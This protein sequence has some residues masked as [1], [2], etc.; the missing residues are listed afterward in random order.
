M[1]RKKSL[2]LFAAYA[3][4]IALL[5]IRTVY[6][7][8]ALFDR[9]VGESDRNRLRMRVEP[10]VRGRIYDRR[11]R[12]LVDNRPSWTVAITPGTIGAGDSTLSALSRILRVEADQISRRLGRRKGYPYSPVPIGR[13]IPFE[14]V[15]QILERQNELTGVTIRME[16]RRSYPYGTMAAHTLGYLREISESDLLDRQRKG[17]D[18]IFGD[19]VGRAGLE[20]G[21]ENLLAGSKGFRYVEVDAVGRTVGEAEDRP[22]RSPLR[23]SDL[24]T[25]LDADLQRIAESSFP[26][27]ARGA[28]V[29]LDPR[30]GALL[31][32][33][34]FPA[35][36][37][38]EF[39]GV[40]D[41]DA[42]ERLRADRQRPLL[43]R[44]IAGLYPPA[45]TIKI[46]TAL[47]GL[48]EGII[49]PATTLDP[50]L[51]GGWRFGNRRYKCWKP[52]GSL[53]VV[54]AI[55]RS[56][57]V[58]FYQLGI[59]LGLR[60]L[61][62]LALS[63]GL[64][65]MN[66]L[67]LPGE[68]AGN[69]PD[70]RYYN[71]VL[72]VGNWQEGSQVINLAVGQGEILVTPLQ[73]AVYTAAVANGGLRVTPFLADHRTYGPEGT[74][75]PLPH[76]AP[77]PIRGLDRDA[78][79]VVRRGMYL[80]VNGSE[81]TAR[82]LADRVPGVTIAGKT[83]TAQNPA[84]EDHAWFTAYAPVEA[85]EIVVTVVVEN[86]GGGSS[87]AAPIAFDVLRAYA[88]IAGL[89]RRRD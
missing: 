63:F 77:V 52:H 20:R 80:V 73:V 48:Q 7:Q 1:V 14:V 54:Q 25:T 18:Y 36:D 66:G 51:P 5:L 45:S 85:P 17:Q 62:D 42:W 40:L 82:Y 11:H 84:G 46:I 27:L 87:V 28:V 58:F 37:P 83:G 29:A 6:L 76:P 26:P 64:G 65:R 86:G 13:D 55:E 32:M 35:Y 39:S 12:L 43:N 71:R 56:C 24:V 21:Y 8:L 61:H 60:R 78:M 89:V 31:V 68:V 47:G 38:L 4:P 10:P 79:D 50:C 23:G 34:S 49:T 15:A 67:D 44:A 16:G 74:P 81:G 75:K 3:V 33:A 30:D 72:G 41:P 53:N 88:E 59:R 22:R 70:E 57:D 19:L 9:M 69:F 2:W